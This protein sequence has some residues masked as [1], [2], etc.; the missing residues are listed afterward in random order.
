MV[1][2]HMRAEA[3]SP[4]RFVGRQRR[5]GRRSTLFAL[6]PTPAT[7]AYN[8]KWRRGVIPQDEYH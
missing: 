1:L 5:C 3:Y 7:L 6:F 8:S 4:V 2:G